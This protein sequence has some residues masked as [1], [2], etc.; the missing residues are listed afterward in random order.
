VTISV[1]VCTHNRSASL[2]KTLASL[3]L[4]A[5]PTHVEWEVLVVDNNSTDHTRQCAED[6]CRRYPAR[7]RYLFEGQAGKSYALN[8]GI[9]A[10][11]GDI[12]AFTDDDVLVDVDWLYKLASSL[13]DARYAGAGGR[14]FPEKGFMPP[15]WFPRDPRCASPPFALFDRGAEPCELS[16]PPFGNN[17]AYRRA[18]FEKHGGFRND[19]GPRFGSKAPQKSED[20]EFGLRLL[21]QGEK[22]RYEPSAIVYHAVPESRVQRS[23]FLSWWFDKSRADIRAVGI[24]SP[25]RWRVAGIPIYLFRRLAVWTLRWMVT[26]KA[27]AR[28]ECKINVW[29][30]AGEIIECYRMW[31]EGKPVGG[32]TA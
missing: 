15:P 30:K 26:T 25:A 31:R 22:F 1:I 13:S 6:F 12:L 7:F 16:D 28:F 23:Y 8:A 14:T 9:H 18:M 10:A 4:S 11:R 19:L 3:A 24:P 27:P 5:V 21:C 20:S 2:G 17:M 32:K 29:S